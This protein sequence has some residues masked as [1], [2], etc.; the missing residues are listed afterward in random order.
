MKVAVLG[1]GV[2]GQALAAGFTSAGHDVTMGTRDPEA[3]RIAEWVGQDGGRR[4]AT[5]EDAATWCEL[6]VLCTGWDGTENAIRLAGPDNLTAKVV[7]D[8]TNPLGH[9]ETGPT[10]AL[11][12][13]DSGGEQ[14]Q[15]W[16][17]QSHVVKT[18]NVL[19][20]NLMCNP[21]AFSGVTPEMWIAGND[22][23]AKATVD[24][25]LTAFGWTVFDLGGIDRARLLEPLAMLWIVRAIKQGRFDFAFVPVTAGQ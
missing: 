10:L 2:V 19:N 3:E 13:T 12:H 14:V 23:A 16:L 5:F 22:T 18:L 6:A 1:S 20:A 17:P 4:A 24:G 8:V 7:I 15:R 25:L 21:K 11:G 9:D